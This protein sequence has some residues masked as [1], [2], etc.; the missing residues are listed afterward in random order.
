VFK[1]ITSR[2]T[3][4]TKVTS[5][6]T[7][8]NINS[9]ISS[10][11]QNISNPTADEENAVSAIT[12]IKNDYL[13][14]LFPSRLAII[15]LILFISIVWRYKQF[16]ILTLFITSI[17]FT[18]ISSIH[19]FGY[20]ALLLLWPATFL[21]YGYGFYFVYKY[22]N[23]KSWPKKIT[24]PLKTI[25]II[26]LIGFIIINMAY[27][28]SVADY[29]NKDDNFSLSNNFVDYLL[30]TIQPNEAIIGHNSLALPYLFNT[31]LVNY[32]QLNSIGQTK[33]YLFHD[34]GQNIKSETMLNKFLYFASLISNRP[35]PAANK[36][37]A[38]PTQVSPVPHE[39]SMWKNLVLEKQINDIYIYRNVT[40][41]DSL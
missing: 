15:P 12:Y 2:Y 14:W 13:K 28:Y 34:H 35:N 30:T 40:Y 3:T 16:K 22:I 27:S 29:I 8:K 7:L 36:F 38:Q 5:I 32:S 25:I 20:R 4:E 9:N 23:E 24:S 41:D 26:A 6:S 39:L 21:L 1:A 17:L 19:P 18:A 37:I 31:E 11:I 33:Y 10:E